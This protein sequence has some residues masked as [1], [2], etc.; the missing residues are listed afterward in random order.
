MSQRTHEY[1]YMITIV[2]L[3]IFGILVVYT[4]NWVLMCYVVYRL[5]K[6]EKRH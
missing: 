2:Y 6:T 4:A 1:D 5:F 3:D